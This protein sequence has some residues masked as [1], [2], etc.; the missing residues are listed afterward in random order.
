VNKEINNDVP[1]VMIG[2]MYRL[3]H[4]LG[5]FLSNAIKFSDEN[6]RIDIV[7]S[8]GSKITDY[9]TFSVR[10]QGPGMSEKDQVIYYYY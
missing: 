4:V 5:N 1:E 3:V 9:V 8:F 7:V 2:D 10:D 6:S